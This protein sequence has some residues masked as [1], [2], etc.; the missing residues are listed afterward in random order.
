M[1][2]VDSVTLGS[3]SSFRLF[4]IDTRGRVQL[5]STTGQGGNVGGPGVTAGGWTFLWGLSFF[6]IQ[7]VVMLAGW[8]SG[9]YVLW[10]AGVEEKLGR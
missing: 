4:S 3:G 10:S 1:G 2:Q 9:G 5:Y 7:D 6:Y 8:V